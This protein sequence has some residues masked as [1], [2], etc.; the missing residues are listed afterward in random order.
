MIAVDEVETKTWGQVQLSLAERLGI[1]ESSLS[2]YDWSLILRL[3]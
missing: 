2:L 1:A 3:S